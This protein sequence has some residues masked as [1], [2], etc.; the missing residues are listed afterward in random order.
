[1]V[2]LIGDC[3]NAGHA[4]QKPETRNQ[5][6]CLPADRIHR[7]RWR[8]KFRRVDLVPQPLLM[9][10]R[11]DGC[12]DLFVGRTRAQY[13]FDVRLFDREQAI[14]QLAVAGKPDAIAVQTERPA[15]RR[16]ESDAP[17]AIRIAIF[18][19]RGASVAVWDLD[20]RSNLTRQG[21]DNLTGS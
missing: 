3:P 17:D 18:G 4:N 13:P 21:L 5:K 6:R 10:R 8:H 2:E 1:M 14:P 7:P 19:S 16:D 15:D 12:R 9:D 20:Q 11:T